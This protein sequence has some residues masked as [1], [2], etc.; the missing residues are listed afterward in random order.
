VAAQAN[1]H[2][3]AAFARYV[4]PEIDVLCRVAL[5]GVMS[6]LHR[7]RKRMRDRLAAAG[8]APTRSGR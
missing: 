1:N 5:L 8:L 4:L 7:A 6:K 2:Q 3:Q